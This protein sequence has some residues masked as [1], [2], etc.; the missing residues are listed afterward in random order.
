MRVQ[1]DFSRSLLSCENNKHLELLFYVDFI[2]DVFNQL[3]IRQEAM[4]GVKEEEMAYSQGVIADCA[5]LR[6]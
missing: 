5:D 3:D 2:P 1:S 4:A 6:P